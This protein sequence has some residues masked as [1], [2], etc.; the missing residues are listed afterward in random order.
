MNNKLA[1]D[2]MKITWFITGCSTGLGRHLSQE[3]LRS[4]YNAVVTARNICD[5]QDIA[6]AY[7]DSALALQLD[8]SDQKQVEQA[9]LRTKDWFGNID[10]LI[11]NAGYGF[12]GAVEEASDEEMRKIFD[13]NFFGTVN[14]IQGVLPGMRKR[15][16]G[17]IMSVSS[18]GG[19]FAAPGSGFYSATKFAIEGMS[20]ALRK[21]LEPLDIRVLVIEPGAF[22]TDFAGRSL[23]QSKQVIDD[24]ESTAGQRRKEKDK[25]DGTQ[26]GDPVKASK[27]IIQTFESD[28]I[29]FRLLLGSD[30]INFTRTELE[31]Q[32]NELNEW[33]HISIK[34]D[35]DK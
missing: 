6:E 19:R 27:V 33:E 9:I 3:V 1:E 15:K 11:N 25:T 13:T 2:K 34:T 18:I 22:R 23:N 12:R 24:Y 29:P 4:G 16:T 20:D 30:A 28:K 17:T 21:E 14:M 5:I 35:F 10:V 7:P 8:I 26:Q 32:I 31:N